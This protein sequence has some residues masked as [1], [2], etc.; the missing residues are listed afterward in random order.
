MESRNDYSNWT[1][2][3]FQKKIMLKSTFKHNL[4]ICILHTGFD[5]L[6]QY[7]HV[8]YSTHDKSGIF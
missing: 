5:E 4:E 3:F 2:D 1:F 6:I 7:K 8:W